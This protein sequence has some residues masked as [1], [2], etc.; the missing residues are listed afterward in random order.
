VAPETETP[1]QESALTGVGVGVAVAVVDVELAVGDGVGEAVVLE[2]DGAEV[3]VGELDKPG[4]LVGEGLALEED[5]GVA[6]G[7]PVFEVGLGDVEVD[8]TVAASCLGFWNLLMAKI[9]AITRPT[10][11]NMA[12]GANPF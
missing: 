6:E 7:V 12:I 4:L 2:L 1:E 8:W 10:I 11:T 3:A 9:P 5:F